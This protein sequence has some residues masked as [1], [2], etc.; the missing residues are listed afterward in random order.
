MV[1]RFLVTHACSKPPRAR[2]RLAS[3]GVAWYSG[4]TGRERDG[5]SLVG[6]IA[7]VVRFVAKLQLFFT[8]IASLSPRGMNRYC[9]LSLSLFQAHRRLRPEEYPTLRYGSDCFPCPEQT[10][11]APSTGDQVALFHW[12]HITRHLDA[13]YYKLPDSSNMFSLSSSA[14]FLLP[15]YS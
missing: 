7:S 5:C 6:E 9:Y 13:S 8:P 3:S 15:V 1:G 11:E 4:R 10:R 2:V 14:L 12:S